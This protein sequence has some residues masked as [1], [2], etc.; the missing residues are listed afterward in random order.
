[1]LII[2]QLKILFALNNI[3]FYLNIVLK[4]KIEVYYYFV[5]LLSN[6]LEKIT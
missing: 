6:Y 2:T 3:Y 1:M 5:D 4:R